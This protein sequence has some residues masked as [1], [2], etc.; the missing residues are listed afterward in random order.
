M[1]DVSA[2][3]R[4]PKPILRPPGTPRHISIVELGPHDCRWPVNDDMAKAEYCG[5]P[6]C[7][8][9]TAYCAD[10]HRMAYVRSPA[11]NSYRVFR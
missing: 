2:P 8:G 7:D 6:R 3:A 1:T 10:H 4:P 5:L 9:S 11:R